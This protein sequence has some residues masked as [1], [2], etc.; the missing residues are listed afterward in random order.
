MPI[1]KV[2]GPQ[3]FSHLKQWA[4]ELPKLRTTDL[5]KPVCLQDQFEPDGR[6]EFCP[7]KGALPNLPSRTG[8]R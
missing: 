7:P 4:S 3:K 6:V 2:G 8:K 5:N 1:I